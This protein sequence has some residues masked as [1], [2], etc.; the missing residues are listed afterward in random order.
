MC[1][2]EQS[3]RLHHS[4]ITSMGTDK[5]PETKAHAE[6]EKAEVTHEVE[7][8]GA[9]ADEGNL[10]NT[11]SWHTVGPRTDP[12]EKSAGNKWVKM[13]SWRKVQSEDTPEKPPAPSPALGACGGDRGTKPAGGRKNPFRRALSEPPGSLLSSILSSSSLSSSPS[14]VETG[15]AADTPQGG[16]LRKYLRQVSQKLKRPRAQNR[17]NTAQQQQQQQQN[18]GKKNTDHHHHL[19]HHKKTQIYKIIDTSKK[20]IASILTFNI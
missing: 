11:Y 14:P 15:A 2:T 13:Q 17:T 4:S 16:K 9:R 7:S 8:K 18:E 20:H 1:W 10:L 3:D 19:L 6:M 12:S 5:E